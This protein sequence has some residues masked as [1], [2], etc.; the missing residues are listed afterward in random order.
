VQGSGS[1]TVNGWARPVAV[2]GS[3]QWSDLVLTVHTVDSSLMASIAGRFATRDSVVGVL[4]CNAA[5]GLA[6]DS[7]FVLVKR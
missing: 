1:A 3:Q 5:C 6:F 2:A 4:T 7:S